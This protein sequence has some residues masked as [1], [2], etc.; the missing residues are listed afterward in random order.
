MEDLDL[1]R[2]VNLHE[3]EE[4]ARARLEPGAYDYFRGG[5]ADEVTLREN[6]VAFSRY[7]LRPRVLS[8]SG[9]IDPASSFLGTPVAMPVG[10]APNALQKLAHPEGEAATARAAAEAGLIQ[11]VSTLSS[12]SLEEI[13]S[14]TAAPKWFQ[15]YIH[16]D[17]NMAEELIA[18]ATGAGYQAIVLTVDL[19]VPGYRDGELRNLFVPPEGAGAGNFPSG[20]DPLLEQMHAQ[21]DPT[22]GWDDIAWLRER[23]DLPIVVKGI[24]T[25]EDA[26]LAV[27]NGASGVWVSNHGGRQ[28]DQSIAAIDA[29]DEIVQVVGGR[30]EV[31][32]DSGV[33]RGTH[34]ALALALGARGVFIGRPYLWGLAAAGQEGVARV[35]EIL[36]TEVVNAMALLGVSRVEQLSRAHVA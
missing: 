7:R 8:L 34:V 4:Y 26:A 19:V 15:L 32:L 33:R 12:C 9:D 17:R 2:I 30:A 20:T 29:L 6:I 18:R 27:E 36:R 31:Y 1:T 24:L 35:L 16:R 10:I 22:I 21:F 14:A 28:L 11:C 13:A 25:A 3:L 23:S 5:A